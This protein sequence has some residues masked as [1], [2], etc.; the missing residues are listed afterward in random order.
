MSVPITF[1]DKHNPEEF[2][3]IGEL[4]NGSDNA[5]DLVKPKLNGNYVY[6]RI[7][8]RNISPEVVK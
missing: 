8:I 5:F 7:A 2:E 1:L 6:K 3:I 4:N